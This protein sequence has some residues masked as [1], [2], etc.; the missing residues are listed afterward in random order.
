MRACIRTGIQGAHGRD[1]QAIYQP[2][3]AAEERFTA[4]L[5]QGQQQVTDSGTQPLQT[6]GSGGSSSSR[7]SSG[8]ASSSSS[9]TSS[10]LPPA[11][12]PSQQALTASEQ[13]QRVPQA[14]KE[15]VRDIMEEDNRQ[16]TKQLVDDAWQSLE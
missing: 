14:A 11:A 1:C 15:L 8:A 16:R 4:R 9:S 10:Q 5:R 3:A 7:N 2:A 6:A 13:L 12:P